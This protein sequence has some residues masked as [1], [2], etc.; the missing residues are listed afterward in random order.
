MT[1][2]KIRRAFQS[3]A[4]TWEDLLEITGLPPRELFS[5]IEDLIN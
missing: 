5:I 1:Y 2:E 4:L 3:G